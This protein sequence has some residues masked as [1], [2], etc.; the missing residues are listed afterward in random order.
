[1][2]ALQESRYEILARHWQCTVEE[3]KDRDEAHRAQVLAESQAAEAAATSDGA[4]PATAS[5]KKKE[6]VAGDDKA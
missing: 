6:V 1:M 2:D 5:S 3:A 4:L